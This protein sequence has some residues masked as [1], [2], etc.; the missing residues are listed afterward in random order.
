MNELPISFLGLAVLFAWVPLIFLMFALLPPRRAVIAAFVIGYLFLP[1]QSFKFQTMPDVGKVSLTEFGVILA[2]FV[3][4]GGRLLAVRPRWIDLACA[5]LMTSPIATSLANGL[6]LMD[7]FAASLSIVFTWGLAY[8]IGRAYFTDWSA[9]RELSM[10]II[11]GGLAYVPFCW[12][13]IR[14]SPELHGKLYGLTFASFRNDTYLFGVRLYGYRPNLF[15]TDGLRVTMFMGVSAVLAFWAWM[16][17][18]PK[19]LFYVPM[20]AIALVLVFTAFFCKALGGVLLMAVGIVVLALTRWPKTRLPALLLILAAP[21]Y[22]AVRST[23]DFTGNFLIET[24]NVL[25]PT[26]ANSLEF[27]LT[28]EN[29]LAAKALQR[30]MLGW[31]GWNRSHVFDWFDQRDLTIADGLWIIVLGQFG[32]IGLGAF[33]MMTSGSAVLLWRRIPARFWTDPACAAAVALAMVVAMYMVDSLFNATFNPVASLA[34]GAV[35]SI[36][37]LSKT[38]FA[39]HRPVLPAAARAGLAGAPGQAGAALG[40]GGGRG[41]ATAVIASPRDL[42]YLHAP[43]RT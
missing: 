15:L 30:P 25:S 1:E 19:R 13:E 18:S 5:V 6:G 34:A 42:R 29:M 2:S 21:T 27:R 12:W 41:A 9:I 17:G 20:W 40:R 31:G 3:F 4:D 14:M 35:A 11:L 28:N 16:T 37:G 24:A 26:R 32:F 22:M 43:N 36:A 7:G 38:V 10:G 8:W 23:G 39:R 33:T